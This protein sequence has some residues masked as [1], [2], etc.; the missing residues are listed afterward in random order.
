MGS[1]LLNTLIAM[2]LLAAVAVFFAGFV[3]APLIL[4]AIGYLIFTIDRRRAG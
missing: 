4:L 2:L 3:L 1:A